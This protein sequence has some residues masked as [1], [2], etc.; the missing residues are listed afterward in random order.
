MHGV[1]GLQVQEHLAL[2][3]LS[4]GEGRPH[5]IA[6]LLQA[7][8]AQQI[9]VEVISQ[10]LPATRE[11]S[12]S[13]LV[14]EELLAKVLELLFVMDHRRPWVSLEQARLLLQGEHLGEKL[15]VVSSILQI[16]EDCG[17]QLQTMTLSQQSVTLLV[18]REHLWQAVSSLEQAF[19]LLA[20]PR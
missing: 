8:A 1:T 11:N 10:A 17:V 4:G 13:F 9:P 18:D 6:P 3:T 7:L 20:D 15:E 2:I 12:V 14:Q 16:L 19:F 5:Q